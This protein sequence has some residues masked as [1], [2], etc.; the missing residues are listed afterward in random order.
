ML[1][2]LCVT[3]ITSW[4]VLYY[5]FPV[6]SGDITA[7]TGWS[8][9]VV[10]AAF[11]AGLLVAAGVGVLVGRWIDRDGPRLVM[12][13]GSVLAVLALLAVAAAPS[14]AW[15]VAAWV[16]G[17][18]A[19]AAVLYPPA[20]AALTRWH[21]ADRVRALTVLTLA[22]GLA[23]TVF[24]PL[25]ASLAAQLDWRSTY[26]VLAVVVAVVTVPGH[27]WGLRGPWPKAD[28]P[29]P[30]RVH[31][32]PQEIARSRPFVLL[33]VALGI[34]AFTAM[35]VIMHLVP[36]MAERGVDTRT[37]AVALGLGGVGQLAGR[38]A[39]GRLARH[40]SVRARTA[41]IVLGIAVT[42]AVLGVVTSVAALVAAA[43]AAGVVRGVFTLLQATAVTD[44]WGSTHYGRLSGLLTAP[45]TVAMALAPWGGA[46]LA[47]L[48]G[49][50]P[51]AFL[52]LALASLTAVAL[53]LASTPRNPAPRRG[54]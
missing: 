39:Y 22:A 38:L 4:G 16:V 42:T 19:M 46:A 26:V 25:T 24:A 31:V 13:C 51:A 43:V 14:P 6:L 34:T 23:S 29:S 30:A 33:A 11:S 28:G 12:T 36:L 50:Y 7:A 54:R 8:T 52:V 3:E 17:G 40:T 35:A 15:F 32:R 27:W 1:V 47:R 9:G 44:R 5:A 48:L 21:G 41:T 53:A 10:T 2:T 37:A 18:A 45:A 20:F 49:G